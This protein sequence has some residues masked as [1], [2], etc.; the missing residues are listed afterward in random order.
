MTQ[1]LKAKG[2]KDKHGLQNTKLNDRVTGTPLKT[3]GELMCS[4]RVVVSAPLMTPVVL[5]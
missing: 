5:I 4:G 2:Q 3:G 1:W